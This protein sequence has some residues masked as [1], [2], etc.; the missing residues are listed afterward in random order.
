M[1]SSWPVT[2]VVPQRVCWPILEL[3]RTEHADVHI[4]ADD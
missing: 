3:T 4:H 1:T 2:H